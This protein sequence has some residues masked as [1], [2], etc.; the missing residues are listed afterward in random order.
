MYIID[1]EEYMKMLE[2]GILEDATTDINFDDEI[3]SIKSVGMKK[4]YDINIEGK[5]H[6]FYSNDVLTHNSA[7]GSNLDIKEVG[8]DA[9][10]D[11][12]GAAMTADFILFLL[13]TP[14]MKE[15]GI[16]TAKCT[17]NR[18]SGR[19]DWWDMNID[20][21]HMRFSDAI[22]DGSSMT[23]T[24]VK[25]EIAS[26]MIDDIKKL[27]AQEN[28]LSNDFDTPIGD[29]SNQPINEEFDINAML[30]L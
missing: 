23:E 4:T 13:Q 16:M 5:D 3:L 21:E 19:T 9:I 7:T 25:T 29:G 11:S 18:F 22:V 26:I 14:E 6:F 30:G 17:K 20:Y 10:S 2:E 12:L 27:K 28:A 8:N 1:S 15:K 24:E